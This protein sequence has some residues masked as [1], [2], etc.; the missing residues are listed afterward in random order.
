MKQFCFFVLI[1]FFFSGCG[2]VSAPKN[3]LNQPS[4]EPVSFHQEI[5]KNIRFGYSFA[6]PEGMVVYTLTHEQTAAPAKEDSE[7]IFLVDGETNF[8]TM[9]GIEDSTESAHQWLSDHVSFFY[10]TGEAGQR[11][12][13]LAGQQAFFLS[14]DGT[15]ISPARL[16]VVQ[17][18]QNMIVIT[19]EKEIEAFDSLLES[20]TFIPTEGYLD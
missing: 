12:G 3:E 9:R 18:E 13:E 15:V 16:I 7:T 17:F 19:Y 2:S 20:F 11:V 8:F 6:I 1:V 10:P 5:Y 14:G 4:L